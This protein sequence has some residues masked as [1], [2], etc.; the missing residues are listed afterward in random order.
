MMVTLYIFQCA[1]IVQAMLPLVSAALEK[2]AASSDTVTAKSSL[3]SLCTSL[4]VGFLNT[5]HLYL[6][7]IALVKSICMTN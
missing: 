6:K 7:L 1:R 3:F 5:K 2:A 4:M